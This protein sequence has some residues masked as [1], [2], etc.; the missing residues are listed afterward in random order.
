MTLDEKLT[1][2]SGTSDPKGLGEAGYI[3]GV[4]RLGIPELRL[5]DGPAG[6]RVTAHA[7]RRCRR[8][9]RWRRRSMRDWPA[10]T[11]G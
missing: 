7:P 8:R 5:T 4:K 3:P 6:V 9:S 1:F 11:D 2:V 10:R